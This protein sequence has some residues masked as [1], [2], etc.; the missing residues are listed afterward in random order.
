VALV[1]GLEVPFIVRK[2]GKCFRLIGPAY[3]HGVMKGE[4]WDEGRLM[5]ITL[6]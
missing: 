4:R 2:D 6:V 5:D 1:A 3:M